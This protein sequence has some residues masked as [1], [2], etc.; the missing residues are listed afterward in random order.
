M[1]GG[2]TGGQQ[3]AVPLDGVFTWVSLSF[4]DSRATLTPVECAS[5]TDIGE[6]TIAGRAAVGVGCPAI[7]MRYWLDSATHLVLRAEAD[8][9]SP[10]WSHRDDGAPSVTEVTSFETV[11][12]PD[13]GLFAWDGPAATARE[14][15]PVA[16]TKLVVG[17]VPPAW[18][19]T[20]LDGESFTVPS[21][22]APAAL[23]LFASW[24]PP[25]HPAYDTFS[26]A[27]RDHPEVASAIVG[28]D[29]QGTLAGFVAQ[30]GGSVTTVPDPD[31][32]LLEGWGIEVVPVIVLLDERGAV[33][34]VVAGGLTAADVDRVLTA[35]GAGEPIP[36]V[37][38]VA[39]SPS[40]GEGEAPSVAPDGESPAP[41]TACTEERMTCLPAG[42]QPGSWSG[43]TPD[44]GA[45]SSTDL[46]GRPAVLW[47]ESPAMCDG[48]C[49]D[50]VGES[51]AASRRSPTG[52]ATEPRSCS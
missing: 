7:G 41:P 4:P 2:P 15:G 13:A 14:A 24:C 19:G 1:A 30:R 36:V 49:P 34:D 8:A 50:W 23:L 6:A 43:P 12:V 17:E 48:P 45:I 16:G 38:P 27:A 31:N 3:S 47:F 46:A 21:P 51:I 29:Q 33:A 22:G 42:T 28:L 52:M 20:A 32:G 39:P 40:T 26:V 37:Q 10:Y 11:D 18:S 5:P 9:A 44:G 35:L 25:C